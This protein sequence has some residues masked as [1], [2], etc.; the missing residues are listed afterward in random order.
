MNADQTVEPTG[1]GFYRRTPRERRGV[2]PRN[3]RKT[4][5]VELVTEATEHSQEF[6]EEDLGGW[7]RKVWIHLP[8]KYH[9]DV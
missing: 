6:T 9:N 1:L 4:R 5:K 8:G 7:A 2:Q 3:T